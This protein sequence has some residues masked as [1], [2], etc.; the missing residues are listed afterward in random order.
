MLSHSHHCISIHIPKT[1]GNSVN[2]AVGIDAPYDIPE[3]SDL[4][5]HT[6]REALPQSLARLTAFALAR[7][8]R[9]APAAGRW[10]RLESSLAAGR[11][12][13]VLAGE[14]AETTA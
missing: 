6:D 1:A 5:I 13:F 8:G 3:Q 9:H 4:E 2:R 14:R 12:E 10:L 11:S 7:P